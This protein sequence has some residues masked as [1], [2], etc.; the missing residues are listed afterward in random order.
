MLYQLI[1]L[2]IDGRCWI[3]HPAM[4]TF[5]KIGKAVMVQGFAEKFQL[6]DI[7]PFGEYSSIAHPLLSYFLLTEHHC[8]DG[9]NLLSSTGAVLLFTLTISHSDQD[10][11]A[12]LRKITIKIRVCERLRNSTS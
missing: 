9:Y 12:L 5:I 7:M 11:T 3:V 2:Q 1:Q 8:R 4:I 10:F 6:R